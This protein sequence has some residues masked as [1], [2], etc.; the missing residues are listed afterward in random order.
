MTY[1][2]CSDKDFVRT[3]YAELI[4]TLTRI[5][6]I[7]ARILTTRVLTA[8]NRILTSYCN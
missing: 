8:T 2:K 4:Y 1:V 3:L 6:T 5:L 7:A